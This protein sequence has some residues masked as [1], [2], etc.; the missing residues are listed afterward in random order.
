VLSDVK[1]P[2]GLPKNKKATQPSG[3]L[4]FV[5]PQLTG[6][7]ASERT[8]PLG[9]FCGGALIEGMC[10]EARM[11]EALPRQDVLSA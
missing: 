3:F 10:T 6:F 11:A 4:F 1:F 8:F 9:I 5:L 2:L 7:E